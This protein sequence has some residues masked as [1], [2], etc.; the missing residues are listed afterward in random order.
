[1][2]LAAVCARLESQ[3]LFIIGAARSGT[4][5][6]QNALNDSPDI[7]LFGEPRLHADSGDTDFAARYNAMHRCWGNQENKS[8]YCP[9][10]FKH[11]ASWHHY[12]ARLAETYRY[13]GAKIVIN[14]EL[15]QEEIRQLFDFQCRYFYSSHYLFTFRNPLDLLMSTRGLAELNGGRIATIAEVLGGYFSVVQLFFLAL[16]NLPHVHV[17]FHETVDS[18]T[19]ERLENWLGVPLPRAGKYYSNSKVRHYQLDTIP[20]TH[21]PLV[22]DAMSLYENFKQTALAG[23][24]LIQIEQNSG[25]FDQNHFTALGRLARTVTTF[26][27]ATNAYDP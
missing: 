15:A 27:E 16:R 22:A 14:P 1:M 10:L 20:E 12:L 2:S 18:D 7:F 19:F 26:I 6:L 24:D 11:D 4:T 8:S 23:F 17:V 25:H 3:G 21:R 13:V 5:V 9:P